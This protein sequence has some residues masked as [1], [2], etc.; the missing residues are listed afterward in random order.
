MNIVQYLIV[1]VNIENWLNIH[2][3]NKYNIVV[4]DLT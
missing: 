2:M 3:Y 4:Y 1:C